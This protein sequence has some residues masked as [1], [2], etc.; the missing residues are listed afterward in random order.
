[1]L[2]LEHAPLGRREFWRQPETKGKTM[3]SLASFLNAKYPTCVQRINYP[4][5]QGKPNPAHGKFFFVGSVPVACLDPETGRSR[6][7]D[8]EQAAIDA[9]IAAGADRIQRCDC[10]F[11]MR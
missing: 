6:H 2:T 8:T 5:H 10:S 4:V 9:A 7:Y 11:V 1:M 3:N